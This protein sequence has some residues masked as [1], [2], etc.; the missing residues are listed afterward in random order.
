MLGVVRT[1][2]ASMVVALAGAGCNCGDASVVIT[3]GRDGGGSVGGDGG[4]MGGG[5]G[6]GGGAGQ[7]GGGASGGG[8]ADAGC[9]P[10]IVATLRDF[11]E[12]HPDF[13]D[14]LGSKRGLV[15][16]RLGPD[17]KPVYGPEPRSTPIVTS[18]KENFDQ[19]YRDVAGVNQTFRETL[20]L[21]QSQPGR[22]VY[23]NRQF[24]PLDGRGFGNE[25]N[26]RNFH[27]TTEI[28]GRFTYRGGEVFT[29]RG[30]DDVFVFVNG[31]LAL[32]LGGVHGVEEG[33]VDFDRQAGALGLS[34]GQSYPLDV[35]HAE[36]HTT[37][38]NFRI[39]TTIDCLV[40]VEIQ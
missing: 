31:R 9:V 8:D 18:T 34:V 4:S 26:D 15:Q 30:D 2:L 38:S 39:E 10:G 7:G 5:S 16:D 32:D 24:F 27:F 35:F 11:R 37:Q 23:D 17:S 14:F 40:P 1:L 13:E 28:H 33:S 21:T 6:G 22:F 36:R 29:F 12:A 25:G 3:P 19:W 20:P